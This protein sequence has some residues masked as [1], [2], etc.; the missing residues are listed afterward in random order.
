MYLLEGIPTNQETDQR[1]HIEFTYITQPGTY[2]LRQYPYRGIYNAG[3]TN[4]NPGGCST[5]SWNT[6]ELIITRCDNLNRIY[7]GT[8]SFTCKDL[9]T[10][11]VVR[12]TDGRFD[13]RD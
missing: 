13:V 6:G 3:V 5:D 7:S 8:F 11:K 4:P 10:G 9:N 12:V 2:Q 1:V